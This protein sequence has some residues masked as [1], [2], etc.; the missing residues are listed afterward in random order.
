MQRK[1]REGIITETNSRNVR[2]CY[3]CKLVL[4]IELLDVEKKLQ[5]ALPT[6]AELDSSA[7]PRTRGHVGV[8]GA[9]DGQA[10]MTTCHG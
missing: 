2:K 1:P 6:R 9:V 7:R 5:L 4:E 3:Q 8:G 10:K